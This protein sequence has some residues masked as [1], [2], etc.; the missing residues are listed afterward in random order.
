VGAL[1]KGLIDGKRRFGCWDVVVKGSEA[2]DKNVSGASTNRG[3]HIVRRKRVCEAKLF[4]EFLRSKA[5]YSGW[6]L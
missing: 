6:D 3:R 1:K 2:G 5:S 4:L